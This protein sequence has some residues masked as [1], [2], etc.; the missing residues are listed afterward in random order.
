[1]TKAEQVPLVAWRLKILQHA[2]GENHTVTQTCRF[3]GISRKTYNNWANRRR[4]HGDARL[5]DRARVASREAESPHVEIELYIFA[6]VRR[7]SA[8]PFPRSSNLHREDGVGSRLSARDRTIFGVRD[9]GRIYHLRGSEVELLERAAQ[10][11]VTFTEDLKQDAGD[12]NRF[13]DDLR[14]LK[15]QGLIEERS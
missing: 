4:T 3:F 1:M 2:S 6:V 9:Q 14:S 8:D 7:V 10:Y 11:R 5:C 15:E 13:K 12:A